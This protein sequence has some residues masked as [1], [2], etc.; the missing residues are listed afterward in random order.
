MEKKK[1]G[2]GAKVAIGCGSGCLVVVL[3]GGVLIGVGAVYLKKMI[4]GY[5]AELKGY[6]FES[7]TSGQVLDITEPVTEPTL[8]KGQ[9]IRILTDSSTNIAILA[10]VCEIHGQ[11]D[12]KLYFRGQVLTVEPRAKILGGIDA[13]AQVIQNNGTIKG[14]IT[15]KYQLVDMKAASGNDEPEEE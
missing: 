10:Q 1:M 15:G 9:V 2:T 11:V 4:A 8:F 14:G 7:V 6:G 3:L 12:G 5:E 13:Q